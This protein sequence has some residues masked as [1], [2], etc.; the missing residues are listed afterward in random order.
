MLLQGLMQFAHP[1]LL[2]A[3]LPQHLN[4]IGLREVA[5]L[6]EGRGLRR[7][8]RRA[9]RRRVDSAKRSAGVGCCREGR[10][11][12]RSGRRVVNTV[13]EQLGVCGSTPDRAPG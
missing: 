10:L 6:P 7:R 3:I 2:K 1:Q 8:D 12:G 5:R 11:P 4:G 9:V 13:R